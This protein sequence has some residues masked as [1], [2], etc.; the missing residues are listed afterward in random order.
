M[1]SFDRIAIGD[2]FQYGSHTFTAEEIVRFAGAYDPQRF[3]LDEAEAAKTH[4]GGLCA[5]GWHTAAVMMRLFVD[6][7]ARLSEEA[8]A[9]G[10][11]PARFGP[12][13][14]FDDLKWMKP[15][16]AGDTITYSGEVTA[17][18]LSRSRPGWGIVT[19]RTTGVN[20]KGEQVFAITG[21]LFA[22]AEK[23]EAD[24]AAS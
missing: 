12:S 17:K 10:E 8:E 14:G 23:P 6:H 5:S 16:F 11:T 3:H 24:E 7:F 18:R 22:T 13:P 4:F 19:L 1:T 2:S 15:V 21:H 20:Q 9:R